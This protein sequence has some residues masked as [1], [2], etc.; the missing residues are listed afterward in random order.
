MKS[1]SW[2]DKT[3]LLEEILEIVCFVIL[4]FTIIIQIVF[5][6]KFISRAVSYAPVWT[7]ELSRWLF[8][9]IVFLGASQAVHY[10]EHIAID[11]LVKKLPPRLQTLISLLVNGIMLFCAGVFIFYGLKSMRFASMQ[12]PLT[13]PVT[14]AMLYGIVPVSFG[15]IFIRLI[16]NTLRLLRKPETSNRGAN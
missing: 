15:L 1:V 6:L 9:Y 13:L 12:R 8:V 7:E 10:H 11:V 5:R 4:F 16:A 3:L 2:Y 14:N